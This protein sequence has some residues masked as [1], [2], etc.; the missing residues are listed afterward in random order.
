MNN[1]K[2]WDNEQKQ[3]G[4]NVEILCSAPRK[5]KD[6]RISHILNKTMQGK[7]IWDNS[8]ECYEEHM[9]YI[10]EGKSQVLSDNFGER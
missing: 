3:S 9:K 8:D 5:V 1:A 2:N 10:K 7:I 4:L 6:M